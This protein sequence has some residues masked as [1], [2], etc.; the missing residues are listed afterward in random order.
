MNEKLKYNEVK[1]NRELIDELTDKLLKEKGVEWERNERKDVKNYPMKRLLG[2]YRKI[3]PY[4]KHSE[5][6]GRE[7]CVE[8]IFYEEYHPKHS[9]DCIKVIKEQFAFLT[10]EKKTFNVD[11]YDVN[12]YIWGQHEGSK[13]YVVY[14]V[15]FGIDVYE[16]NLYEVK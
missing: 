7:F 11:G 2:S 13:G 1:K 3:H 8:I 6:K 16:E 4:F 14:G 12:G 9:T 5:K 10:T 15:V